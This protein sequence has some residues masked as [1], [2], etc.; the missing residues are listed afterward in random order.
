MLCSFYCPVQ[1]PEGFSFD[2]CRGC[3]YITIT[4]GSKFKVKCRKNAKGEEKTQFVTAFL[5][6]Y[7]GKHV[8]VKIIHQ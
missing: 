1:G 2:V 5:A 4:R 6:D 8:D 3:K 7:I